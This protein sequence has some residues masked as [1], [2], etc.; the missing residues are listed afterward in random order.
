MIHCSCLCKQWMFHDYEGY[1]V[2]YIVGL[3]GMIWYIVGF[4]GMVYR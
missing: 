2:W 3:Y 4:Y 1:V